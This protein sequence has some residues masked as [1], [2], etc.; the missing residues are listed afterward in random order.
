MTGQR[1]RYRERVREALAAHGLTPSDDTPP[2]LVRDFL[3]DLYVYEIRALRRQLRAGAF[4]K[5]EYASRVERL[6]KRY[7]LLGLPL[8]LWL[9]QADE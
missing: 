9:E 5:S 3:N 8:D 7:P 4:P 1:F 6:R 2:E